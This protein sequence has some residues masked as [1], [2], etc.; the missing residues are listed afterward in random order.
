MMQFQ[1]PGS[2]HMTADLS[3]DIRSAPEHEDFEFSISGV[4]NFQHKQV[5]YT[6]LGSK[7]GSA[8]SLSGIHALSASFAPENVPPGLPQHPHFR[9]PP[10]SFFL[11]TASAWCLGRDL[12]SFLQDELCA[13]YVKVRPAKFTLKAEVV[14][15]GNPCTVKL[16]VYRLVCGALVVELQRRQGDALA[17][18][19]IFG[20]LAQ[21]L[22]QCCDLIEGPIAA[23]LTEPLLGML[24]ASLIGRP[25]GSYATSPVDP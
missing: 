18:S 2:E 4:S 23:P 3:D 12:V 11:R 5:D 25:S 15:G 21:Y 8:C 22:G 14:C 1:V 6:S 13:P 19:E 17:F 10:T 20:R 16:R 9:L 7:V 24:A